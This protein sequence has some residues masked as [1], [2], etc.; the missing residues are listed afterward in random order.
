VDVGRQGVNYEAVRICI[1]V[2]C[3]A[4][5]ARMGWTLMGRL[6]NLIGIGDL[7]AQI[8]THFHTAESER[9]RT[10]ITEERA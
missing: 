5:L 8:H 3:L 2:F 6:L 10:T 7:V 1:T 4:A 9:V